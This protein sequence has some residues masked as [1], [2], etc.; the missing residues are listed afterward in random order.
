[1]SPSKSIDQ[2]TAISSLVDEF[3]R[4]GVSGAV[5][6][7]GSR[8]APIVLGFARDPRVETWSLI[9]E[10]AAGFFA[11]GLAKAT[12]RP[13]IVSCTS[14]TAVAELMPAVMEAFEARVPLIVISADR[15]AELRDIGEGQT[16]DQIKLFGDRVPFVELAGAEGATDAWWRSTACRAFQTSL[17]GRPGPVHLNI[18]LREPLIATAT[19]TEGRPDGAPWL[20]QGPVAPASAG[21]ELSRLL[22][23]SK[24]PVLVCGRDER[25]DGPSLSQFAARHGIPLIADVL[26]GARSGPA[27][28]VN[29]DP[30]LRAGSWA[31]AHRP[32]LIVRTGDLPTSKPL[33][34]WL[35]AAARAGVPVAQFDPDGGW[36]DPGSTTSLRLEADVV[37]SLA[38][39]Q[40][41]TPDPTWM[42]DWTRADQAVGEALAAAADR[43]QGAL[44]EPRVATAVLGSL[45]D[46]VALF[47]GASMPIR[48]LDS[49]GGATSDSAPVLANRGANGI[50][51]TLA[52]AAG[53]AAGRRSP[54]VVLCGDVTFV[55]DLSGLAAIRESALP[56]TI[57]VIDNG[58]GGIFD[59]LPVSDGSDVYERFIATPPGIDMASAAATWGLPMIEVDGI[60]TLSMVV[61]EAAE[62]RSSRVV[63]TVTDRASNRQEHESA[64]AA[65]KEAL[66]E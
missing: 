27:A 51:G 10:R 33:R 42:D 16:I 57:V 11:L 64:W 43:A 20:S 15:P 3:A 63:R 39:T 13:A 8:S 66:G 14:G 34:Q 7:P 12:G 4:C 36:R 38:E 65:A 1:M 47:A 59:F 26:S 30:I 28:I 32:D 9:D 22:S 50:D 62:A 58:G 17:A 56:V 29:W 37:A 61:A 31:E 21:R 45:P 23:T 35:D 54:V 60:E 52:T 25:G 6:C 41:A 40:P 5:L 44:T 48:D 53:I 19:S 55:H 24:R 18:P 49:F 2:A 46:G